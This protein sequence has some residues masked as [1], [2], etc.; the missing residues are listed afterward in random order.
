MRL[1]DVSGIKTG[2]LDVN[3]KVDNGKYPFFTCAQKP[4]KIDTFSFD[5]ECVLVAGN[6][7]LN[8]KYYSGKF[9]AYQRTY[10]IEILQKDCLNTSFLFHFLNKYL[11]KLRSQSIGGVIKYIKMAN[12]TDIELPNYSLSKQKDIVEILNTADSLRQK[13]KKQLTLLDDYLKSIF[14]DMFGDPLTNNKGITQRKIGDLGKIVTGNTPSRQKKEYYGTFVEWIKSDNINTPEFIL[15]KA[16]EF[17]SEAGAKVGRIA[18]EGAILVT[19]I[20]GSPECIG[21]C[22]ISDRKVAFN[23][24]IN[25]FIPGDEIKTEFFFAQL[26][27]CKKLVQKASTESMKGMVSKGRFFEIKI[28]APSLEQQI[29]FVKIF[30]SVAKMQEKMRVSLDEMYNHFNALMRRYFG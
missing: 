1:G 23:Q 21:N 24:Q 27:I 12:L 29:N 7:D 6:G 14:L 10:V 13:R 2:N 20:A 5:C 22:A 8:V 9:D 25:A 15:T 28:L 4:E 30:N 17:L 19:C 11:D 18:P 3:V 16:E 26:Y